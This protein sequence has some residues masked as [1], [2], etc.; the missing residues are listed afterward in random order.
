LIFMVVSR[1]V[2]GNR[3]KVKP[4]LPEIVTAGRRDCHGAA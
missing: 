2:P 4:D 1:A 3:T